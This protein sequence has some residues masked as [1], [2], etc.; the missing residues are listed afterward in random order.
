MN[1]VKNLITK[2]DLQGEM[3]SAVPY[4]NGHIND[5]RLVTMKLG[6]TTRD[7]ILQ[8]INKNV[9]REYDPSV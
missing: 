9:F 1:S 3:V 2:F 7:Y 5:T 6:D 8:K 4:G